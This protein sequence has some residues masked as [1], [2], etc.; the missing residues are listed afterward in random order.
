MRTDVLIENL[1]ADLRPVRRLPGSTCRT[2][3]WLIPLL[4][5]SVSLLLGLARSDTLETL[6][7]R[8]ERWEMGVAAMTSVISAFGTFSASKPDRPLWVSYL[9]VPF[10]AAWLGLL[11]VGLWSELPGHP[12][13]VLDFMPARSCVLLLISF[14]L[15]P[16]MMLTVMLRRAAPLLAR[17]SAVLAGLA[18]ASFAVVMLRLALFHASTLMPEMITEHVGSLIT[19]GIVTGIF[20]K[21][22]FPGRS[23]CP[24]EY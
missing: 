16:M 3:Y 21:A 22:L 8:S 19:L 24:G 15:L 7:I 17:R 23:S 12:L 13:S 6:N 11:A 9:P 2:I 10:L 1:A 20:Y 5:A 18:S 4:L 14:S